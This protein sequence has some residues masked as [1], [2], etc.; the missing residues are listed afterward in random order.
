MAKDLMIFEPIEIP[1]QSQS[2][3]SAKHITSAN[4]SAFW[5][6]A[7]AKALKAKQGCYVFAL[8]ASQGYCPWYVGKATKSFGQECFSQDKLVKYN[9]VLFDGRKGTPVIFFVAP[10]GNKR[11]VPKST[12]NVIET[13]LIQAAYAE[14]PDITNRQQTKIPDWTIEG[15]VRPKRGPIPA[16]ARIFKKMMG[17]GKN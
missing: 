15:V 11:K 6:S 3:G 12:C 2:T 14:N 9:K 17:L 13:F 7:A 4:A 10:S 1:F 5:R 16:N 8:R